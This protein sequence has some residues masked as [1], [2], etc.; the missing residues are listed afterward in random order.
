MRKIFISPGDPSGIGP[1]VA[2]KALEKNKDIQKEFVLGGDANYYQDFAKKLNL[3]LKFIE[4]DSSE[5]GIKVKHFPL[6]NKINPG[7]PEVDNSNYIMDVLSYLS[8][9]HI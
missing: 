6:K 7:I 5:N 2:L 3:E 8:L 9:I 4:E 1:E